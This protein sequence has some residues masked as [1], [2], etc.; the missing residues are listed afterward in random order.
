MLVYLAGSI[1][2]YDNENELHKA[3]GWRINAQNYLAK[4][5]INAFNPM[6]NYH[7]N[8]YYNS[9]GVV[10]QNYHYLKQS[11]IM[12][13]NVE[14]LEKSYGTLFEIFNFWADHKPVIAFGE[15]TII[16]SPHIKEAIT[17]VFPTLD[18]TL[19]YINDMYFLH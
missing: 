8:K 2:H 4:I 7:V 5:N 11:D 16:N 3:I 14:Y 9:K 6:I 19:E 12:L 13:L 18:N 17:M 1:T 15:N 10:S